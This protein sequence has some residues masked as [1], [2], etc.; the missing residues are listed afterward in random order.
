VAITVSAV[1]DA[2]VNTVPGAQTVAEDTVLAFTGGAL[3]SVND[4]DGNLASTQLTVSDGDLNVTL[5]GAATIS[6]GA[7]GSSTLTI[8][9]SQADINATLASL[10]YQGDL[11]F[12]GA[13][14]L[15]VVSTDSAGTPLSDTDNVA[16]TVSAVNDA[17]NATDD[18]MNT[19]QDTP[20][21]LDVTTNDSD[22]DSATLT[23]TQINGT[24]I[25]AGGASVAVANG[26]VSLAADGKTITF[27]P[28]GGYNGAIAFNY[29]VSDGALTATANLTGNVSLVST[30][31]TSSDDIANPK[32][33]NAAD[34]EDF[35]P[36]AK[37]NQN[38]TGDRSLVAEGAVLD[39][40][41]QATNR[42]PPVG[43]VD[44]GLAD[45]IGLWDISGVKGFSVSF[46]VIESTQ[47]SESALS[48]F[49]LRIGTSE[50]E[51]QDQLIVKS[52]L[53]D[54]T[55]FL[56]L[57]YVIN[58]NP[59]LSTSNISV[60]QVDG[61]P[62]PEWLRVDD[63]GGLVSGEPP[64]GVEEIQIRIE[65]K[66]NNNTTIVRYVDV[67]VTSGEIAALQKVGDEVIA[68]ASLFE[69]QIEK[70]AVKFNNASKDLEKTFIN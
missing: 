11:N 47:G 55:L 26:S 3:I 64:V 14:S 56:E 41:E 16:I 34:G 70:E 40:V 53:R 35:I 33:I 17:P 63:Q 49:P 32:E 66:L 36:A 45:G 8:S 46:S 65:V 59:D 52:I 6:A 60:S 22:V 4:V 37:S 1:N 25:T 42:P 39:A 21:S 62:L 43:D 38:P 50:A 7:N 29:T 10:T 13:D 48:L 27:I 18:V 30:T 20:V 31:P 23:V 69:N 12:N 44:Y 67:N 57:D 2:P 24:A 68:G 9:G 51:S 61:S 15:Q 58:S 54:R 5:S 19:S 28:T